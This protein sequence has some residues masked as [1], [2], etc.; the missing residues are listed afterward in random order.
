MNNTFTGN[1]SF[2]ELV[3][4]CLLEIILGNN[5]V[6][7]QVSINLRYVENIVFL[8]SSVKKVAKNPV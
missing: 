3:M 6:L 7:A 5:G 8:W 4:L 1:R 2:T